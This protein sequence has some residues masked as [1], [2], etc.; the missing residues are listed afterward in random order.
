MNNS[1]T[2]T[3]WLDWLPCCARPGKSGRELDELI[4]ARNVSPLP[5]FASSHG[6][7]S[8]RKT[9]LWALR[10]NG[11]KAPLQSSTL[12]KGV[13]GTAPKCNFERPPKVQ[14][15]KKGSGVPPRSATLKDS[16][17]RIT[18]SIGFYGIWL[19]AMETCVAMELSG[20]QYGHRKTLSDAWETCQFYMW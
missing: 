5:L 20:N 8:R 17:L 9:Q 3:H 10:Q 11:C 13:R 15:W 4:R 18:G 19:V 1:V 7:C 2:A 12:K 6:W 14:L 16:E